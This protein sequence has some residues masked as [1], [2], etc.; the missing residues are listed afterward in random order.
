MLVT[1]GLL[2]IGRHAGAQT[3][4]SLL[5][6][7]DQS[8]TVKETGSMGEGSSPYWWVNSGAYLKIENGRGS[9]NMGN[10]PATDPWNTLYKANNPVDTDLGVHPQNIFRLLTKSQWQNAR[11]E[12]YF[13]IQKDNLS[14]SPNRNASN[15]IL[16]FNRY[17]DGQNLYYAGIRVD[18]SAIIK[19]KQNGAYTT[20]AQVKNV[21]G[22]GYNRDTNPNLL[23]KN[24]WIGLRSETI[25]NSDGSVTIKLYIDRGWTG[26][27]T[28]IAEARDAATPILQ[29]GHGGIRTDFI[30]VQFENFRFRNI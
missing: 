18:G 14:A 20:L 4:A 7:F 8:G 15:G 11:Q 9:T 1:I 12:A 25:N 26:T 19:K 30:D 28:L 13:V 21:Y 3:T 24:K 17:Q 23:P 6:N 22:T 29:G 10:L 27:W 5:Y 16:L 2:A